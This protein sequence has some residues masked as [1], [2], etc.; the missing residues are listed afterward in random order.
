MHSLNC[1]VRYTRC[2]EAPLIITVP[3]LA[4]LLLYLL[5]RKSYLI[6]R[7]GHVAGLCLVWEATII[8]ASSEDVY[9]C[10]YPVL[11]CSLR[12]SVSL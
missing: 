11:D 4:F 9:I 6:Y 3:K 2:D 8:S 12:Q 10:V 1:R 7:A 5:I